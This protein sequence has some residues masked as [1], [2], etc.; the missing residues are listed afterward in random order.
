[1]IS[2]ASA[3]RTLTAFSQNVTATILVFQNN[4]TAAMQVF[5]TSPYVTVFFCSN[6]FELMLATRVKML[7]TIVSLFSVSGFV[8]P[9][10]ANLKVV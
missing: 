5:Q 6:K 7:C 8:T 1:M 3:G 9:P 4:E 2:S 10:R